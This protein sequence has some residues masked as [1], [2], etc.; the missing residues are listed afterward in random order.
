LANKGDLNMGG[1]NMNSLLGPLAAFTSDLLG[2]NQ[3]TTG[4]TTGSSSGSTSSNTSGSSTPN[5]SPLQQMLANIFGQGAV[6]AYDTNTNLQPYI[7][8]GLQ[9]INNTGNAASTR[10]AQ[11]MASRGLASSPSTQV[12]EDQSQL[13][14]GNQQS[15]FLSGI[16]LLQQQIQQQQLAQLMQAFQ[17]MPTGSS[18]S[19]STAGTT[20]QNTNAN[21]TQ[22]QKSGLLG[23]F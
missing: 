14:T 5:L 18:T 4:A 17:V 1:L 23:L 2:N 6:N 19:S 3:T 8:G 20:N 9:N 21:T 13:N 11:S 10:I 16:P 12:A 7:T 22:T 15:Q